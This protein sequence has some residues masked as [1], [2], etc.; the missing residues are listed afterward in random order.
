MKGGNNRTRLCLTIAIAVDIFACAEYPQRHL[1]SLGRSVATSAIRWTRAEQWPLLKRSA[2]CLEGDIREEMPLQGD[3]MSAFIQLSEGIE[4]IQSAYMQSNIKGGYSKL[5]KRTCSD[6]HTCNM[7]TSL[8]SAAHGHMLRLR[9]GEAGR[10]EVQTSSQMLK[11]STFNIWCPLFRRTGHENEK[12]SQH[13]E[14]YSRR[15]EG[16]L[17][18]IENVDSD[19]VCLQEVWVQVSVCVSLEGC[20]KC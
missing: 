10:G 12:E 4:K 18:M 19:I 20:S 11:V 7:P 6:K 5:V 1:G 17:E 3:S 14:M 16:I 2:R 13:P 15:M 8:L 9:G